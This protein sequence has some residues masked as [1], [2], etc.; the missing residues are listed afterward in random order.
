M[1]RDAFKI[2][3]VGQVVEAALVLIVLSLQGLIGRQVVAFLSG[4]R[5]SWSAQG[6]DSPFGPSAANLPGGLG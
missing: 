2:I 5:L 3:V 6:R 1:H 4:R